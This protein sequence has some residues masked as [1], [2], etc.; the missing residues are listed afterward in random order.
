MNN[1]IDIPQ[2]RIFKTE[3]VIKDG[4]E[5]YIL[6]DGEVLI[7]GVKINPLFS[8]YKL[9]KELT[10]ENKNPSGSGY[11]LTLSTQETNIDTGSYFYDVAL[12]RTDGELEMIIDSTL[13]KVSGAVVRSEEE[14]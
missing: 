10:A 1:V 13:F 6:D 4:E 9:K 2:N 11:I 14:E 3:I 12:K 8:E 5:D 7:F